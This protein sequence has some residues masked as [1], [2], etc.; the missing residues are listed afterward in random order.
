MNISIDLLPQGRR[1]RLNRLPFLLG[2]AGLFFVISA[3]LVILYFTGRSSI[4]KLD[5]QIATKTEARD[6]MLAEI[7]SR[8]N[9]VTEYNFVDKYKT[10]YTFL[11]GIYKNPITLKE[12]LY[13]LLPEGGSVSNYTFENTGALTMTVL[14]PSKD[15]AA[16]YLQRLLQADFVTEAKVTSISLNTEKN[17]YEAN[18]EATVVTLEGEQQ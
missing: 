9:G 1:E 3:L 17:M 11:N 14:F 16:T 4:H 2:V 7:T 12:E 8:R 15:A 6:S 5:E 18:F 10:I 13:K